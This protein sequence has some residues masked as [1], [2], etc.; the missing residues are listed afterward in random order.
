MPHLTR[1]LCCVASL[2]VGLTGGAWSLRAASSPGPVLFNRDIRPV[3]SDKCY[4]CHGPDPAHRKGKLRLDLRDEAVAKGAIVPGKPA[5]SKLIARLFSTD[6]DEQ[7]PPPE[8]H[9]TLTPDQKAMFKR[10]VESGAAYQKHWSYEPPIRAAVPAGVNPIDH[11]V[12]ARLRELGLKPSPEADRRILSRRLHWDLVGLPPTPSEV[13]AF[14]KDASKDAY[15]NLAE[16]LMASPHYGERMAI[17]W[18]DVARFADTIGYH[19]DNPRNVWPYRNYVIDSFNHNK[20]FDLFT[21]E[22]IAGDLFPHPTQEQRV[23]S[24]FN[25]L[26]LTTEEGGAQP[27]DYEVRMMTDR[28]RAVSSIWLGQTLGCAQCHDHKFDP[29]KQRDFY[30]LGAFFADIQEGIIAPREP[31]MLVTTDAQ[32]AELERLDKELKRVEKQYEEPQPSLA[33][34]FGNWLRGQRDALLRDQA[35]VALRPVAS[36]SAGGATLDTQK[37]LSILVSGAKPDKDTYTLRLGEVPAKTVALRLEAM[38]HDS[39]PSKGPGRADNGN[40]VVSEALAHVL[41]SDGSTQ[42]VAFASARAGFEQTQSADKNPYKAWLAAAAIDG[43]AKGDKFGWAVLPEVGKRH[44]MVLSLKSPVTL[45]A[46]DIFVLRLKQNNGDGSHT[47]GRFRLSATADASVAESALPSPM[48]EDLVS[49]IV[50][51][52]P[53]SNE[54]SPKLVA[55]HKGIAPELAGLRQQIADARKAHADYEK[56][57]PRCLVST[58]TKEARTVRILPRGNWM[59]ETGEILK[60]ALPAY[61]MTGYSPPKDR[62]LNRMDLA[63]WLISRQ[64]PLTARVVMNRVWKQFFGIGLSKSVDDLGLQGEQPSHPELLDWL[65]CEFME[66][67]WDLKH[68][69]GLMVDSHTYKQVST[70]PAKLLQQDPYNRLLARQGRWRLDAELVRDNALSIAGMLELKIG[71][72]S[73]K[74]YQPDGYWE[75]LNFPQRGY[76]ASKDADQ[77]RRGLYTWWQRSYTHP[78]MVA[79]D[80]PSREECSADRPRSNIPQQA[81]VLL[82]D[83]TYVEAARVFAARIVSEGGASVDA[84]IRWAWRTAAQRPPD[85]QELATMRALLAKHL[86]EYRSDRA[87]AESLLATGLKPFPRDVDP[88]ELAAWTSVARVI[89]NLHET[90]TRS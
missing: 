9:K 33:G 22:Q 85:S 17:G 52:K 27:K 63:D 35:W 38:P 57:I 23:A 4:A 21:R 74:P 32:A 68:M 43:D 3:L 77:Y 78:S 18:L 48:S 47:L 34:V 49:E 84:R 41:K 40:F 10:W 61:L 44:Q 90:L 64:N 54:P 65:A 7:M 12:G 8:S 36:E 13:E 55:F 42:A 45:E 75:N 51:W 31:G 59:I 73:V 71:G 14:E 19:S 79:F 37:D 1:P 16:R 67:G 6:P 28:V 25:R 87:A 76:D 86:A 11:F 69:I 20:P 83:P 60:P 62:P 46:Q 2:I 15:R 53:G 58:S 29:C 24:A 70:A 82:N 26:L 66:S 5:E 89:L 72:P 88:A 80:A 39:L 56:G 81:L 50:A 30:S